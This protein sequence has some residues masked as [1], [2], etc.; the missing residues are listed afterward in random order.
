MNF[1]IWNTDTHI[2]IV[3][4]C[5]TKSNVRLYNLN[6]EQCLNRNN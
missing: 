3:I 1:A 2:L 5:I 6:L 4:P